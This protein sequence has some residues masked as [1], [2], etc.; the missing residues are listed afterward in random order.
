[1]EILF[2]LFLLTTFP[3]TD[4][5]ETLETFDFFGNG[6][7]DDGSLDY[8]Q[9]QDDPTGNL[10]E[11]F[12]ICSSIYMK[13]FIMEQSLVQLLTA[14][15]EPWFSLYFLHLNETTMTHPYCI[16]VNGIY[17][18][19]NKIMANPLQW[20]HACIGINTVTGDLAT[21]INNEI[22]HDGVMDHFVASNNVAP[23][24]LTSKL[25]L[26]KW[27][28][29]GKWLQSLGISSNVNVFGRKLSKIEML[30]ITNG[31]NCGLEG[32]YLSWNKM[33]WEQFN[34]NIVKYQVPK[35]EICSQERLHKF[36]LPDN[37]NWYECRRTCKK[38][39]NS[40]MPSLQNNERSVS[41][42][43]WFMD[44]MFS[45]GPNDELSPFP[46]GCL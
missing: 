9:L 14:D 8:A 13:S 17:I 1:M 38:F 19:F 11:E 36:S 45:K 34:S 23:T 20:N 15:G 46:S 22:V 18:H 26:G 44:R 12:T 25:I 28:F 6:L 41:V 33:Q 7:K 21:S 39:Q 31:T 5:R 37:I 42:A 4:A 27:Y 29:Q 24:N 35:T 30:L 2:I 3:L 32:D 43:N 10:P 16:G 40:H